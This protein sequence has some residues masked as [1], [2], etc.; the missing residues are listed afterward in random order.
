MLY[1]GIGPLF[2]HILRGHQVADDN[3]I[4]L[5]VTATCGCNNTIIQRECAV[6]SQKL[7][8]TMSVA[9]TIVHTLSGVHCALC[10]QQCLESTITQYPR[11]VCVDPTSAQPDHIQAS[12]YVVEFKAHK[13]V[14]VA[15]VMN[16]FKYDQQQQ[17]Q[18][19][20]VWAFMQLE[21]M[22]IWYL[23]DG[24]KHHAEY[25][26]IGSLA[27]VIAKITTLLGTTTVVG[28]IYHIA[29]D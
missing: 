13:Y 4:M 18:F 27:D 8:Q 19:T 17:Q 6:V 7:N 12:D 20:H 3:G 24:M 22:N 5:Q 28:Y 9:D 29:H 21:R 10:K 16:D 25:H 15:I 23:Y 11:L 26:R 14:L 2:M 1:E